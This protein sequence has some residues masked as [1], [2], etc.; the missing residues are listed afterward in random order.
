MSYTHNSLATVISWVSSCLLAAGISTLFSE[1]SRV[2]WM[3]WGSFGLVAAVGLDVSARARERKRVDGMNLVANRRY[4]REMEFEKDDNDANVAVREAVA[5]L[6]G[7]TPPPSQIGASR[8]TQ[9]RYA[10]DLEVEIYLRQGPSAARSDGE[11]IQLARVVGLSESGFE[12]APAEP[13]PH[14]RMEMAIAGCERL[15]ANHVR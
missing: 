14:L 9:L 8:R 1:S 6:L 12:L 15:S 4:D 2:T 13:L 3:S 11:C 10:C 5:R 7:R